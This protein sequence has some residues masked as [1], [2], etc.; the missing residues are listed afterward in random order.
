MDHDLNTLKSDDEREIY[1]GKLKGRAM[2]EQAEAFYS[3]YEGQSWK[4]ILSIGDSTF[5]RYGLL[6][7]SSAYMRDMSI[8]AAGAGKA[9]P[10]VWSPAQE[11]CWEKVQNGHVKKLRAKCCKLVDQPDTEE[12]AV[13]LE[14]IG[15]WLE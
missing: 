1:W 4:N 9:A 5:E 11:G 2:L 12:L 8:V 3:Q 6:A 14:M 15:K 13:Q 7:A 10:V